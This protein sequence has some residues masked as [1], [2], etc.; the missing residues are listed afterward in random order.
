M[1]VCDFILSSS[2]NTP[3]CLKRQGTIKAHEIK[4]GSVEQ[5]HE[6]T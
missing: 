3:F 2:K 5:M 1:L 6:T 4:A